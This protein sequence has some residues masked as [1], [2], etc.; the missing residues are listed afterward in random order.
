MSGG[1]FAFDFGSS[2]YH[3]E[4][5]ASDWWLVA[6]KIKGEP[7]NADQGKIKEG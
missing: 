2:I 4:L 3:A 7:F 6:R 5:V 1:S